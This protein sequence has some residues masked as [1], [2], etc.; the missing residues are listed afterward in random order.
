M[1]Q[2]IIASIIASIIFALLAYI[3]S[4]Y[5]RSR[6]DHVWNQ[7]KEYAHTLVWQMENNK[8]YSETSGNVFLPITTEFDVVN[9]YVSLT[10]VQFIS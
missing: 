4:G 3:I 1:I 10:A 7:L 5:R 2:G 9:H 8:E 6:V